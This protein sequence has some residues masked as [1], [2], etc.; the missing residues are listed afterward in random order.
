MTMRLD[1]RLEADPFE[2]LPDGADEGQED[3]QHDGHVD[4]E[5]LV[6]GEVE[7]RQQRLVRD[8]LVRQT[9]SLFHLASINRCSYKN[10]PYGGHI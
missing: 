10:K 1:P 4:G 3:R 6:L 7:Q 8:G 2:D 9:A 5:L